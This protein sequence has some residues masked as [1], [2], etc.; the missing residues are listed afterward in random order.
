MMADSAAQDIA[1]AQRLLRRAGRQLR[2]ADT[3]L[4]QSG[5]RLWSTRRGR[6]ANRVPHP[7]IIDAAARDEEQHQIDTEVAV[8]VAAMAVIFTE[9]DRS[10]DDGPAGT[11]PD[12]DERTRELH[13]REGRVTGREQAADR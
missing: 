10:P 6:P 1:R 3:V 9:R 5:A 2:S 8:S 11:E 7:P 13:E 12:A 4:A